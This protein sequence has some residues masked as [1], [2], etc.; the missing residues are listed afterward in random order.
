MRKSRIII[1]MLVMLTVTFGAWADDPVPVSVFVV[2]HPDDLFS[3]DDNWT[4]AVNE[5][6]G[7]VIDWIPAPQASVTS[8]SRR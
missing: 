3:N 6:L 1:T 8:A 5:M 2:Q 4:Q 7:I